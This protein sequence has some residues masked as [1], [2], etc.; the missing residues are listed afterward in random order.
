MHRSSGKH[1]Y[2]HPDIHTGEEIIPDVQ[3]RKG[4]TIDRKVAAH[5]VRPT[6]RTRVVLAIVLGADV[7]KGSRCVR[8]T[9]DD[10]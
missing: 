7:S 8:S 2:S 6:Q 1:L 5:A 9:G 4:C 3:T 10:G